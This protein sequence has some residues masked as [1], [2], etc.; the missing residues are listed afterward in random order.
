MRVLF[1]S[2]LHWRSVW[3]R[4]EATTGTT[5]ARAR[6]TPPRRRMHQPTRTPPRRRMHPTDPDAPTAS[7]PPTTEAEPP[8][9]RPKPSVPLSVTPPPIKPPSR[10]SDR[11]E[12]ITLT[13][14]LANPCPDAWS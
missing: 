9:R 3:P 7:T 12:P 11:L 5:P 1:G 4:V 2:A 10:P 13:G 6:P 8:L 14:T